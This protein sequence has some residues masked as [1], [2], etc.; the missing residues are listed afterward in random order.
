[1]ESLSKLN[2]EAYGALRS[3]AG[4][5]FLFHGAQKLF[6]LFLDPSLMPH[7]G[8]Q[9]WF[10]GVIELVGGVLIM[11]GLCTRWAAFLASGEMA[12]AYFQFHWKFVFT[13]AFFPLVNHGEMAVLYCF[14]F[15]FIATQGPGKWSLDGML[16][17][18]K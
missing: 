16:K 3:V 12:V 14:V 8:T 10:G 4:F 5:L 9:M 1:M 15:L 18:K 6:G 17:K 7:F 13:S 11:V 2:A